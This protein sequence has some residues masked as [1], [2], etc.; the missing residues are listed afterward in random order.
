MTD[1]LLPCPFCGGQDIR[2]QPMLGGRAVVCRG[3]G[4]SV[5]GYEPDASLKAA[6]KWNTRLSAQP[7]EAEA[8]EVVARAIL[9][10]TLRKLYAGCLEVDGAEM[11]AHIDEQWAGNT[12]EARAAI[13]AYLAVR[14]SG[15]EKPAGEKHNGDKNMDAVVAETPA[16]LSPEEEGRT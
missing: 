16:T 14:P 15:A 11:Q 5:F 6:E 7:A 8:V 2:D 12:E 9:Q 10:E 3:C 4:A 13:A 1:D